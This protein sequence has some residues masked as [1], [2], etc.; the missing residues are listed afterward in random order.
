MQAESHLLII[1]VSLQGNKSSYKASVLSNM[2]LQLVCEESGE[3][4]W[5]RLRNILFRRL[6]WCKSHD[7]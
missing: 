2:L 3:G 6:L 4:R 5:D 1:H 7:A